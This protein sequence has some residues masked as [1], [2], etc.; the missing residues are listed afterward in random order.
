MSTQRG[1]TL[2]EVIIAMMISG[3]LLSLLYSGLSNSLWQ[4]QSIERVSQQSSQQYLFLQHLR[5]QLQQAIKVTDNDQTILF[6]GTDKE[7]S[8]IAP[9]ELEQIGGGL[10]QYSLRQQI[11]N[12][13]S[14]LQLHIQTFHNEEDQPE[15][16]PIETLELYRGVEPIR[17]AYA[18]ADRGGTV[19][20]QDHWQL[21][22]ELPV[23]VR[24]TTDATSPS[25]RQWPDILVRIREPEY[26]R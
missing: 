12:D 6:N 9:L 20:W 16:S 4:W 19:T 26:A 14:V 8:F 24:L 21:Q 23:A 7:L 5:Q 18:D 17:F 3:L 25:M 1:F 10:Y 11:I 15:P 2:L 13:L 22:Q